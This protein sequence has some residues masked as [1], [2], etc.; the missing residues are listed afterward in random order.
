MDNFKIYVFIEDSK[1]EITGDDAFDY[2]KNTLASTYVESHTD[3]DLFN[4]TTCMVASCDKSLIDFTD[5]K[6]EFAEL[7]TELI[8]K[9]LFFQT[10]KDAQTDEEAKA[11]FEVS[12]HTA[13][14]NY[15]IHKTG[16][17]YYNKPQILT[18]VPEINGEPEYLNAAEF[19]R[20]I[21]KATNGHYYIFQY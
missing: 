20:R 12:Y 14:A 3:H 10:Q 2:A 16:S 17:L 1:D 21:K 9:S 7:E 11:K 15:H 18:F 5:I 8:T 19:E 13:M 4:K 6:K